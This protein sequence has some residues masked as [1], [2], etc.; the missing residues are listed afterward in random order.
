[1]LCILFCLSK[2]LGIPLGEEDSL[3]DDTVWDN[4]TIYQF[5]LQEANGKPK[6]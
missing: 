4:V 1:M 5:T 3:D 6:R 2:I